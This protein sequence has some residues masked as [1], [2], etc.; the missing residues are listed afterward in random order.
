[1]FYS[2]FRTLGVNSFES[3]KKKHEIVR[4]RVE[5]K[6][7]HKLYT[8]AKQTIIYIKRLYC[9]ADHSKQTICRM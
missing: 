6:N 4:P 1:M 9:L 5:S 2:F 7:D 8:Y 3:R